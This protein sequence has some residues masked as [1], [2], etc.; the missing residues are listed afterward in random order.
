M[1][2]G[3]AFIKAR[4]SVKRSSCT[5]YKTLIKAVLFSVSFIKDKPSPNAADIKITERTLPEI[6]G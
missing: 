2:I 4:I 6:S 3:S 5:P 1:P